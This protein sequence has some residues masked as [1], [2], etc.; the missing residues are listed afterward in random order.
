[1]TRPGRRRWT[2][3]VRSRGRGRPIRHLRATASTVRSES[4]RRST[5][6]DA[7]GP[8]TSTCGAVADLTCVA[9][10]D[11][12]EARV[13]KHR[14]ASGVGTLSGNARQSGASTTSASTGAGVGAGQDGRRPSLQVDHAHPRCPRTET[15]Y[16]T[17]QGPHWHR[18]V[19]R[20]IA[21]LEPETGATAFQLEA[22]RMLELLAARKSAVEALEV[23]IAG[24]S[25]ERRLLGERGADGEGGRRRY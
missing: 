14:R 2:K 5:L 9:P 21:A 8:V 7:H 22:Q 18:G 12:F 19:L 10:P 23:P 15:R 17:R 6:S 3:E 1:M 4:R 25:E 20:F 24:M 11:P 13:A 16:R